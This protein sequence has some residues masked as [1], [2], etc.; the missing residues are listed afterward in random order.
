MSRWKLLIEYHGVHA[1]EE[2][3]QISSGIVSRRVKRRHF[4]KCRS[5]CQVAAAGRRQFLRNLLQVILG[6]LVHV[7]LFALCTITA[8]NTWHIYATETGNDDHAIRFPFTRFQSFDLYCSGIY[9]SLTQSLDSRAVGLDISSLRPSFSSLVRI[10][11]W[12][13]SGLL[14]MFENNQTLPGRIHVIGYRILVKA[15]SPRFRC[16]NRWC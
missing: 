2:T 6:K 16:G 7:L 15:S 10:I 5:L 13:A 8:K 12:H 1:E 11:F 14:C 4:S 3:L 9:I